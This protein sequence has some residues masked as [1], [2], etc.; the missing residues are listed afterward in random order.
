MFHSARHVLQFQDCFTYAA[1]FCVNYKQELDLSDANPTV[2]RI[3]HVFVVVYVDKEHYPNTTYT[4][5]TSSP[6][7]LS[8]ASAPSSKL[9]TTTCSVPHYQ[10]L[11]LQLQLL[12]HAQ[13]G[14]RTMEVIGGDLRFS[15]LPTRLSETSLPS[16]IEPPAASYRKNPH[17]CQKAIELPAEPLRGR[18]A[19][20]VGSN[21]RKKVQKSLQAAPPDCPLCGLR[22]CEV[23]VCR[24][25]RIVVGYIAKS[26]TTSQVATAT[27]ATGA[28]MEAP[29]YIRA[30]WRASSVNRGRYRRSQG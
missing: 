11:Q 25:G 21:T 20:H 3:H 15:P 6:S 2:H 8:A 9:P 14:H 4:V 29:S 7:S 1:Y 23:R 12:H 30:V 13:A 10:L 18:A 26:P 22:L 24:A 5:P 16:A 19:S 28:L 17:P 27:G